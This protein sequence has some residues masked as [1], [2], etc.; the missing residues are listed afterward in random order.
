MVISDIWLFESFFAVG[1]VILFVHS[2][3]PNTMG[4]DVASLGKVCEAL[5]YGLL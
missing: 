1:G 2:Y 3:S 5:D 4:L